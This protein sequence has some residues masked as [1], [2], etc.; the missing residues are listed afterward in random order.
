[1]LYPCHAFPAL[2]MNALWLRNII[3]FLPLA[4][5]RQEHRLD[6]HSK[7]QISLDFGTFS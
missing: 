1:M 4:D 6:H 5:V 2:N 7:G 3:A